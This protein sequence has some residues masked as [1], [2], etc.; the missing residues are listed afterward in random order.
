M[1]LIN[2][3][4]SYKDISFN[5]IVQDNLIDSDEK[6]VNVSCILPTDSPYLL[7]NKAIIKCIGAKENISNQNRNVDIIL[8]WK[9]KANN[10]FNDIIISWPLN[11]D[12][13]HKKNI[14]SYQLTG[15]SIRQTNFGCHNN[16]FD[17]YVYIYDLGREPKLSFELPL[18]SPI[19][20]TSNCQVFDSVTLKCSIN[21]KHKKL[22][23]GTKVMLPDKG[24]QNEIFTEDGNTIIF[25]MNN[26]TEINNNHD[27]YVKTEE[28]C[29]DYLVVGALKDM[30]ISHNTSVALY[31]LV[32]I[33]ICIFIVG[34]I[35]YIAYNLRLRYKKGRK[36]SVSE[37]SKNN[38]S[39]I[40][41]NKT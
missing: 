17:F 30:G 4:F 39:N 34:F 11:F 41:A 8:N 16:N 37:E 15:L 36:L 14:Y 32:I 27:F 25:N 7:R 35:L 13:L 22:S 20:T 28:T 24:T 21:L 1:K 23:K 6:E 31:V 10:N 9:L 2:I 33:F 26:L 40:S 19:S 3:L 12:G 18:S 29:G 38:S 5:L